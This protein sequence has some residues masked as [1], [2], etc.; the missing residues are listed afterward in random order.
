MSIEV[1]LLGLETD[2]MD[3]LREILFSLDDLPFHFS[4]ARRSSEA[5]QFIKE[6]RIEI[7]LA[8]LRE[9]AIMRLTQE[10]GLWIPCIF[11]AESKHRDAGLA[12]MRMGAFDFL[13]KPFYRDSTEGPIRKAIHVSQAFQR[14]TQE[15]HDLAEG[16]A[17]IKL[18]K[19]QAM[20]FQ[21]HA[22]D[23]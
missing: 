6:R 21:S 22:G 1:L 13:E 7:L 12:A 3:E 4:T 5:L 9:S 8:D 15:S 10:A 20:R 19:L 11:L 23:W 14:L 18:L 2:G 16:A 17:W